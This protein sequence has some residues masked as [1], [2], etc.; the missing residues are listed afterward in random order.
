[1]LTFL[2]IL[3][4]FPSE[5]GDRRK[6]SDFAEKKVVSSYLSPNSPN[7]LYTYSESPDSPVYPGKLKAFGAVWDELILKT[8]N[9]IFSSVF[10]QLEKKKS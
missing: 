2:K 9:P 1:M 7:D 10:G 8:K 5:N 4:T 3:A 6:K